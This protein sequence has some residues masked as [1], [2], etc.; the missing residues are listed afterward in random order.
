PH[1]PVMPAKAG[2]YFLDEE[3]FRTNK[4]A[5]VFCQPGLDRLEQ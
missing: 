2:I 3:D 5:K 1:R 4:L